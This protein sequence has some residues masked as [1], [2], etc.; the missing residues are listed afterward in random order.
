VEGSEA[1]IASSMVNTSQQVGGS[2]GTSLLSTIFAG[3]ATTYAATHVRTPGLADAAAVHR[4]TAAFW[5]SFGIFV[6]GFLLALLILPGRT[7]A[8][9]PTFRGALARHGIGSCHHF[10]PANGTL[11]RHE[12]PLESF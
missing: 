4:Y 7:D 8:W 12:E 1:G 11:R 6:L 2:V 10:E 3:A 5:W 9:V